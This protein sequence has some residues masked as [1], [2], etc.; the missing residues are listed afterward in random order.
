MIFYGLQVLGEG[1]TLQF[2]VILGA[3]L[4]LL[5]VIGLHEFSHALAASN[6]GDQTARGMGRISVNPLVHLDPAGTV[7]LLLFGF[8]W[9]KPTPVN[10]YGLRPGPRTGMAMV[11]AAGPLSNLLIAVVL[12]APIR[13]GWVPWR[14]PFVLWHTANWELTDFV[15]L[16]LSFAIV[17]NILLAVFNLLPVAPL[18]GFSVAIG[19]LPH[20]LARSLA[21]L[22]RYGMAILMVLFVMLF[23]VLR[24]DVM[25]NVFV[26][27]A[28]TIAGV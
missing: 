26:P 23:F 5:Y 10:P 14:E 8:G 1:E 11:A 24:V 21:P 2:L 15:G 17:L 19:V 16:F 12:A 22:E 3:T 25:R 4:S 13:L 27:I 6:L 18:D 28:K 7:M 20:E 9:G